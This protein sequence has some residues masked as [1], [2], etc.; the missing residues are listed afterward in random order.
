MVRIPV[1]AGC[2]RVTVPVLSSTTV[3]SCRA[4]CSASPLRIRIPCPA[5]L[6]MLTMME[7][8]VA[9]P[10]AQGQAITS[11]VMAVTTL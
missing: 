4:C 10:S 11:T 8:G 2:P 5:A 1:T 6:P 9:S 3:V 7:I